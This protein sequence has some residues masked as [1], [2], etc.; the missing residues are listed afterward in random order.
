M[1]RIILFIFLLGGGGVIVLEPVPSR[2]QNKNLIKYLFA[3]FFSE[4]IDSFGMAW[5]CSC[6]DSAHAWSCKLTVY[7]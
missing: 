6:K 5:R 1:L 2:L 4:R 7:N 3:N